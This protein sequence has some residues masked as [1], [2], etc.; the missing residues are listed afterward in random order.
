MT[1]IETVYE[2]LRESHQLRCAVTVPRRDGGALLGECVLH[3]H[4]MALYREKEGTIAY[5]YR[6]LSPGKRASNVERGRTGARTLADAIVFAEQFLVEKAAEQLRLGVPANAPVEVHPG[7]TTVAELFDFIRLHLR[8][9]YPSLKVQRELLRV[10]LLLEQV[11]DTTKAYNLLAPSDAAR[12]IAR[13]TTEVMVLPKEFSKR[14]TLK[15]CKKVTAINDL[16][17]L[18]AVL[19]K[20][21]EERETIPG[22]PPF[23]ISL[24]NWLV[25]PK[26]S[27]AL[28]SK[29]T[30]RRYEVLLE[31]ADRVDPTGQLRLALVIVRWLGRRIGAV[32]ALKR[33]DLRLT[34][35]EMLNSIETLEVRGHQEH[36]GIQSPE[37]AYEFK[38]GGIFFDRDRDKMKYQRL[39]P[40]SRVIRQEVER[41]L[42]LHPGL[43]PNGPLFE[44]LMNRGQA[45]TVVEFIERLHAAEAAARAD[46]LHREVPVMYGSVFHGYRGLRAS[47]MENQQHRGMHV[48]FI[49]GWSCRLGT[50][51][52]VRYVTHDARLLYAAVEGL[53]PVEIEEEY[54]AVTERAEKAG[55]ALQEENA[56]LSTRLAEL[57][58]DKEMLH[59][60]LAAMQAQLDRLERLFSGGASP[61]HAIDRAET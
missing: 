27:K 31:Y 33:T 55:Q 51:K 32:A 1:H 38:A 44:S 15:P 41:Y 37:F 50:T 8:R 30:A 3:D 58:V 11:W 16:F 46:S 34:V 60:Q 24:E 48:N 9:L 13:R 19:N 6:L 28:R 57:Q 4:R 43:D 14:P 2:E 21:R 10:L 7:T 17:M 45:T 36:D 39:V 12:Y 54:R 25:L 20:I 22:A 29:P 53:R 18:A 40:M 61:L 59:K 49:V 52:E 26:V 47:E 23:T 5:R 42:A 56:R 35:K